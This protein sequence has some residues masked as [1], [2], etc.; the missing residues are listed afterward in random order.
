MD[1]ATLT[2]GLTSA[3]FDPTLAQEAL[4][5]LAEV[6]PDL[7][8]NILA[9][10]GDEPGD[11][12]AR[13]LFQLKSRAMHLTEAEGARDQML[14]ADAIVRRIRAM[15]TKVRD[16]LA[17][18]AWRTGERR[19]TIAQMSAILDG[20][21]ERMRKYITSGHLV[22]DSSSGVTYIDPSQLRISV[23]DDDNLR[24]FHDMHDA[25][26]PQERVDRKIALQSYFASMAE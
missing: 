11:P 15:V 13:L 18:D 20:N 25:L 21:P 17:I 5:L 26:T 10:E 4:D 9:R 16:E 1:T 2:Q 7:D 6:S 14:A 3:D 23:E 8:L 12:L 24:S 22:A 19:L